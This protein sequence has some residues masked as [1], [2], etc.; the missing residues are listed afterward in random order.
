MHWNEAAQTLTIGQRIGSFPGMQ[1]IRTF[2]VVFVSLRHPVKFS[3][4]ASPECTVSY[5]GNALSVSAPKS[6]RSLSASH[7]WSK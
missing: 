5:H 7:S 3:F 4:A 1:K 6:A 2:N